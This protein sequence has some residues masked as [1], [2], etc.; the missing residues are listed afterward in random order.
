VTDRPAGASQ[1]EIRAQLDTVTTR[2]GLAPSREPSGEPEVDPFFRPLVSVLLP[3]HND[4]KYIVSALRSVMGQSYD[5]WECIVVDDASE[6]SSW[7]LIEHE[8][9][10]NSRFRA[11]RNEVNRGPGGARNIALGEARGD[12]VAFLDADDMLMRASLEDRVDALA[13]HLSNPYVAGSFC[14]VRFS[15]AQTSL[16][17]LAS[18]YRSSQPP[19]MDFVIARGEVP[20][21][22]TA[23]LVATDRLRSVGGLDES[24]TEGGV[25]WDLWYRM[26][27]NG[28]M[29]VSSPFQ[30]VV[31]RQR[32]GG[33]TRGNPAAHT[34]AAARL[35]RAAHE[36]VDPE[37]LTDPTDYPMVEP[38]GSYQAMLAIAERAIR[39]A[40]MTLVDG[41]GAGM[42]ETL[43]VLTRGSWPLLE[44]HLDMGMLVARGA[45]RTL[46]VRPEDVASLPDALAPLVAEMTSAARRVAS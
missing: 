25:D 9:L 13:P 37:V 17:E 28:H 10:G 34:R 33:I 14:G 38:L 12:Y 6:D 32:A 23:P 11:L 15:P 41:D 16:D 3:A 30:S 39:F 43:G 29:F 20:F 31:Y 44:R 46:G 27:R 2:M 5:R 19:F 22:M 26:L 35:I 24:M 42:N 40:T 7:D 21:P 36:P 4:D 8:V 18:H 45:A 1:D